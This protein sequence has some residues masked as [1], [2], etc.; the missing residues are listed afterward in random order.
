MVRLLSPLITFLVLLLVHRPALPNSSPPKHTRTQIA[1]LVQVL[2]EKCK[3][4]SE[5]D[6]AAH[7]EDLAF[8]I[9]IYTEARGNVYHLV[10]ETT[11]AKD[12]A[13]EPLLAACGKDAAEFIEGSAAST[14]RYAALIRQS[15]QQDRASA[16]RAIMKFDTP[17][18]R[19]G[20]PGSSSGP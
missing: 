5:A 4:L 12:I 2:D 1:L 8:L 13:K 20:S 3:W 7:R 19:G 16:L 18:R 15:V 10:D 11:I 14:R 9:R 17:A 6:A